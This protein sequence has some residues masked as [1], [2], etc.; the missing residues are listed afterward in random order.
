[1]RLVQKQTYEYLSHGTDSRH[2]YESTIHSLQIAKTKKI[3]K[4]HS[5]ERT[6][7]STNGAWKSVRLDMEEEN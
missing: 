4:L 5:G 7:C 6:V 1:M 2:R 3:P